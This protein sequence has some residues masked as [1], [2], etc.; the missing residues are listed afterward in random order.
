[1]NK[2]L[3][4]LFLGLF[5]LQPFQVV[6][7]DNPFVSKTAPKKEVRLPS[8]ASKVFAQ[9][10][11]WQ[12]RLNTKLTEQVKKLKTGM[13][14]AT[15]FPLI[16][17]SFLYGVIHAA[18]PGHGK[19]VVFSYFMS[20]RSRIKKGLLLGNLISLFHAVSGIAIV[21]TLYFLIKTAYLAS[22]EAISRRIKLLSYSLVVVIG[23]VLLFNGVFHM[24]RRS[25]EAPESEGL[26]GSRDGGGV[27]PWPPPRHGSRWK[28][29]PG[30][31]PRVN[32]R[33]ARDT[34]G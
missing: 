27:L 30:H 6:A 34:A 11:I 17:V 5:F 1:M 14:W 7:R 21:L 23:L 4:I 28:T 29:R 8:V 19:V 2:Y 18:G 15:L 33:S 20:R 32:Q 31:Y 13:S 3:A 26:S 22:F 24:K 9:I 10:M 25:A 12:H 16:L